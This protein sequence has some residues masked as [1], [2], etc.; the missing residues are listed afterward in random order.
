V[1]VIFSQRIP[2]KPVK[3]YAQTSKQ[4]LIIFKLILIRNVMVSRGRGW[5]LV[6]ENSEKKLLK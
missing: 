4:K 2:K 5:W 6:S 1:V 3:K